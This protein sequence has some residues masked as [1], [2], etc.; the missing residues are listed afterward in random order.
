ML[1][2]LAVIWLYKGI[3]CDDHDMWCNVI[4]YKFSVC[5]DDVMWVRA[6]FGFLFS[7]DLMTNTASSQLFQAGATVRHCLTSSMVK[8]QLDY[9]FIGDGSYIYV[10]LGINLATAKISGMNK[11]EQG[12]RG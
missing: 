11:S 4:W 9:Y 1:K 6:G 10:Y 12:V 8:I 3:V 2:C 5:D 7:C